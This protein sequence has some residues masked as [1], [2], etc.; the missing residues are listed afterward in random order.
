MF[1][2]LFSNPNST[3][4]LDIGY[5]SLK[6]VQLKKTASGLNIKG[7]GSVPIAYNS[8]SKDGIKDPDKVKEAIYQALEDA[9]PDRIN[10]KYVITSL[11]ESI[12]FT[13]ILSL[14][15][16]DLNSLEN[17]IKFEIAEIFP[18]KIDELYYDWQ[19]IDN[20]ESKLTQDTKITSYTDKTDTNE[21]DPKVKSNTDKV[22]SEKPE[23]NCEILVAAAPK[24]IIDEYQSFLQSCG[25]EI[26][27]M[28]T[29]SISSARAVLDP[30]E[31]K[32]ILLVDIGAETANI[33]IFDKGIM[34]FTGTVNSG[35]NTTTRALSGL[36]ELP[37][38]IDEKR[39]LVAK[40]DAS[41]VENFS[42]KREIITK[43]LIPIIEEINQA[44]KYY[45]NR[46]DALDKINRIIIT[47]G[48]A[49]IPHIAEILEE[50][51]AHHTGIA[52][53]FTN[54]KQPKD[55]SLSSFCSYTT[56]IGCALRSFME[57]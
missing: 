9:E 42:E 15:Y 47:G 32:G 48:G 5:D 55:Q 2:H 24:K 36:V 3:L 43:S 50:H 31:K 37:N 52:N 49:N 34:R 10:S 8:F 22:G 19:I 33:S 16:V 35:G 57:K 14:P 46:V 39:K 56:A 18:M 28:E 53:P 41:L 45:Q 30:L 20:S 13:K 21:I 44:I 12:V 40:L 26:A 4:G 11:Q 23:N 51:T 1:S 29:K 7:F 27:A 25:L 17:S 54:I 6:V 38:N